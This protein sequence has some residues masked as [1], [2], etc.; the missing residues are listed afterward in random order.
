MSLGAMHCVLV[1]AKE[2]VEYTGVWSS[3]DN[4]VEGLSMGGKG[5]GSSGAAGPDMGQRRRGGVLW[6]TRT[7]VVRPCLPPPFPLLL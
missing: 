6:R 2:P 1:T 7:P 5:E 3:T 4:T